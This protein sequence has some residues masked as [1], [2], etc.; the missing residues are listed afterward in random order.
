[1]EYLNITFPTELKKQLDK[2]VVREKSRR[3]TLIQKAVRVY[4][5][6]KS[7]K[8]REA[9]LREGYIAMRDETKKIMDDF[10]EID[11]E[12]LKYAD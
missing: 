9:L 8:D 7:R 12:S 5:G 4:L 1:M 11:R 6:L 2:E 3:S 10:K